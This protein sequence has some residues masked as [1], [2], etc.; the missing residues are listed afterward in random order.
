MKNLKFLLAFIAGGIFVILLMHPWQGMHLDWS[1]YR[2]EGLDWFLNDF[3][4]IVAVL[5]V[6]FFSQRLAARSAADQQPSGKGT[7]GFLEFLDRLRRSKTDQWLGGVCG[8]LGQCTPVPA[9]AW[10]IGF[11]LAGSL[12]DGAGVVAYILLWLFV[13]PAEQIVEVR[14]ETNPGHFDFHA[15]LHRLTK[16][17]TDVQVGGVCGGLGECTPIPAWFWRLTFTAMIFCYG[18]GLLAYVL[19]WA[20]VPTTGAAKQPSP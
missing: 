19:L 9:W 5:A 12:G 7:N 18:I 16:S 20:F 1:V 8:G 6:A 15:F 3:V 13:P 10:R 11:V 4:L 2:D 14:P 17:Q